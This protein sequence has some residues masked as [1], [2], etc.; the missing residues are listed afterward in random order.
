MTDFELATCL[1]AKKREIFSIWETRV[2]DSLPCARPID[3]LALINSLPDLFDGLINTLTASDSKK[4]L[5]EVAKGIGRG[6]GIERSGHRQYDLNHVIE[7]Y[8]ILRHVIFE[9]VRKVGTLSD[10]AVDSILDAITTGIR[11]ATLEFVKIRTDIVERAKEEAE[12]AN[13]TKSVFLANVSHEIRTP[14]GAIIGYSDLVKDA[15]SQVDREKYIKVITRNGVALSKLINDVLDYS[16]IE[17][18]RLDVEKIG[19]GLD[20]LLNEVT[21]LFRESA[22]AKN[23]SIAINLCPGMPRVVKSDPSRLRQLLINIIGNA[24][25]FTPSGSIEINVEPVLVRRQCKKASIP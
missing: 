14:L 1:Q 10:F 19:F 6:H 5:D 9:V 7:E 18:G 11:N 13:A 12:R 23:I 25:K 16:K 20:E 21:G 22:K 15:T 2:R 8:Q 24:V 17:A 3:S 4:Y